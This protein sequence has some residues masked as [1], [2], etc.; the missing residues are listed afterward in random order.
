M[1]VALITGAARGIGAATATE[2]ANAGY[3]VAILDR[4]GEELRPSVQACFRFGATLP[5]PYRV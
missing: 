5:H 4:D 3:A 2:F 1:K